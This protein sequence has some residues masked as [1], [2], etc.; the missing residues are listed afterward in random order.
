MNTDPTSNCPI[1]LFNKAEKAQEEI[2]NTYKIRLKCSVVVKEEKRRVKS[3]FQTKS[4]NEDFLFN[5]K[6]KISV[7]G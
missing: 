4:Y 3:I 6:L 2:N 7:I 1:Y 5:R